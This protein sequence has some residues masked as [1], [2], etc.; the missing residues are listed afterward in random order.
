MFGRMT[1]FEV[2]RRNK[3]PNSGL[4]PEEHTRLFENRVLRGIFGPLRGMEK[5][6]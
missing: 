5:T 2:T 1:N 6:S 3:N 4:L